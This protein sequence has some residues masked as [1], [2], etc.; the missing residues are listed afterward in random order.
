MLMTQKEKV[1]CHKSALDFQS[2]IVVCCGDGTRAV[3]EHIWPKMVYT[4]Q[5]NRLQGSLF[6]S[7]SLCVSFEGKK[8]I[9]RSWA[10][11]MI[12]CIPRILSK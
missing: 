11:F 5:T 6:P 8:R 12:M 2:V 1:E 4:N 10:K 9:N 7:H 3:G